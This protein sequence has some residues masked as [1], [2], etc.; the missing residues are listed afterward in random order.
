M[1]TEIEFNRAGTRAYLSN[2][3]I[4][5]VQVLDISGAN[6]DAPVLLTTIDVG[7]NPRGMATNTADTRLYVANIQSADISVIDIAPGSP[8]ENQ[9]LHTIAARATDDIVGGRA[10][11]WEAFVIGGRAPRGVAFSDAQNALFVTSIGPQ[12]GPR[13]GVG[14]IGGAIINPTI[15][16]ID[17]TTETIQ[18][19]VAMNPLDR[20]RPSCTDPEL[21]VV[22]DARNRLYVTCQGSGTVDILDTASLAAGVQAE[23]AVIPLPLPTD[24]T[25]PTLTLNPSVGGFG[26]KVC[27]AFNG[28]RSE[29]RRV[30]K[31]GRAG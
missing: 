23:L 16:V 7:V 21:M 27:N 31:D 20:D 4:D 30:G 29:E 6:L 12:T 11:G 17:G 19:H 5:E 10:D 2:E 3:N 24:A 28:N 25:V 26:A 8:T 15:T 22:D 1:E 13:S 18:A 9:I 14:T